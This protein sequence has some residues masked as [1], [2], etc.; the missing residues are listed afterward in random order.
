MF[1][2]VNTQQRIDAKYVK[3]I[4]SVL[5]KN[6]TWKKNVNRMLIKDKRGSYNFFVAISFIL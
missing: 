6:N 2:I 1:L 5:S 4:S 3:D